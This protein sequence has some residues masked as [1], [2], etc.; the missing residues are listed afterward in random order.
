VTVDFLLENFKNEALVI[1]DAR[2]RMDN[3]EYGANAYKKSHIENA[4]FISL[5]QD[6]AGSVEKHGGRHPLPDMKV[7]AKKLETAGVND[8]SLVVIYDDG[9]LPAA[10]RLWWMLRYIGKDNVYVLE[11]GFK[12]WVDRGL[13]TTTNTCVPLK[14]GEL[15]VNLR[16]EMI[17][18]V[19]FVRSNI[20]KEGSMIVDS[21]AK[22]RYLGVVEPL[23]KKAGHILG[24]ENYFWGENFE[25]GKL[26]DAGELQKNLNKFK[27]YDNLIVHCGSGIT[28][29]PNIIAMEETGLEPMLYLGGWSDWVSYEENA[30]IG[31]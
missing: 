3:L 1:L 11:G 19:D 28:A 21:R 25:N 8:K 22:E 24:A 6:M 20:E 9:D 12:E 16:S 5:E 15:S 27:K 18:D 2:F 10:A 26:K 13:E 29:C 7:F 14:S 30:V 23:D 4:R 17:C 31:K